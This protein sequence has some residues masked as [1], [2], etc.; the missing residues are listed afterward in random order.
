MRDEDAA[1]R[2]I[3]VL[4]ALCEGTFVRRRDGRI[5]FFPWGALGHGYALASE[6]EHR[7]LRRE[8]KRLLVL[9]LFAA[10]LAASIGMGAFGIGP[11][12]ALAALLGLVGALR[13]AWLTRGL[14]R[15]PGRLTRAEG[16]AR[17][18]LALRRLWNRS[19]A[20]GGE[21]GRW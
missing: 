19:D 18:A 2:P 13:L 11:I 12:A 8:V 21:R 20:A 1:R 10:P 5:L 15:S 7:R 17:V 9:G 4:D 14:E 3:G 6:Q 16:N